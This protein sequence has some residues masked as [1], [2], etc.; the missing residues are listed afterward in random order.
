VKSIITRIALTCLAL[1]IAL[2]SGVRTGHV[3][4]EEFSSEDDLIIGARAIVTS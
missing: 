3:A 4:S 2:V 1:F